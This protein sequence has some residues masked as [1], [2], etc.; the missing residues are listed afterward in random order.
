MVKIE[1][2][3]ESIELDFLANSHVD[4][5]WNALTSPTHRQGSSFLA[6]KLEQ[7]ALKAM[8]INK[9]T[10]LK[11]KFLLYRQSPEAREK[12]IASAR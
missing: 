9:T 8:H 3:L 2:A 1:N 6:Y 4:A 5:I 7:S 11:N 12:Q 10:L